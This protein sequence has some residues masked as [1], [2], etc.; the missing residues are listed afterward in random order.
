MPAISMCRKLRT[1]GIHLITLE[2]EQTI[3]RQIFIPP[4]HL[5]FVESLSSLP[6]SLRTFSVA[7]SDIGSSPHIF[8]SDTTSEFWRALDSNLGDSKF[9]HL[10]C[11]E[12]MWDRAAASNQPFIDELYDF[13][14]M[15]DFAKYMP[16]L[17]SRG[18]LWCGEWLSAVYPISG[19]SSALAT[20]DRMA[21]RDSSRP[22]LLPSSSY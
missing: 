3:P 2:P 19:E 16:K 7:L 11:V 14:R 1:F 8:T 10:T 13:L 22:S 5:R 20:Y 18:I 6:T 4:L 21:W 12:L 17:Y 15:G 9:S